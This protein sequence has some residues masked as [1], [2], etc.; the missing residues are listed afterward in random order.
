[1]V[2]DERH[3]YHKVAGW[4]FSQGGNPDKSETE[5]TD[6]IRSLGLT[7]LAW[8]LPEELRANMPVKIWVGHLGNEG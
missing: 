5:T 7:Q 4:Y 6:S 8:N 2:H 1:M 3:E